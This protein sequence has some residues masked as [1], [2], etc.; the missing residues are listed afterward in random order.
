MLAPPAL[1]VIGQV[2]LGTLVAVA[3]VFDIWFRRIP[4]WLV[5]AGAG[6]GLLWNVSAGGWSG[7]G[8]ALAGLGLG[9]AIYF[10]LFLLR[11]LRG[12]DI[13][14]LAAV[15]AVTGPGNVFW[16]FLLTSV[17]GGIIAFFYALF[18][19]HLRRTMLNVSWIVHDLLTFRAPYK[20]SETL[21]VSTTKG[22]RLPHAP[23]M[24]AGVIAFILISR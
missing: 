24:A 20:S 6:A 11:A 4:N 1:A 12:G 22:T 3:S 2:L 15:G 18:L 5:L 17:L 13:K 10:P 7:F 23:L 16:I 9:F 19:G 21:D 8:R 14:L